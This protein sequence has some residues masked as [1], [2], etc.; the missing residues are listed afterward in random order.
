[1]WVKLYAPVGTM[2]ASNVSVSRNQK[3]AVLA[4]PFLVLLIQRRQGDR[5]IF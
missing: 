3:F 2:L 5:A 4:V 1:M